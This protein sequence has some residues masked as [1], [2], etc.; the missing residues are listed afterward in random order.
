MWGW[1]G[2]SM[3]L[4]DKLKGIE[5]KVESFPAHGT[6]FIT[7]EQPITLIAGTDFPSNVEITIAFC[8][9]GG[10]SGS[11]TLSHSDTSS[12]GSVNNSGRT[13]IQDITLDTYGHIT[14]LVSATETVV[15]TD[16]WRDIDTTPVNGHTDESISSDWAYDHTASSTAHPRDTRSQVAGTYN[17]II[18]TDGDINTSGADV[19]ATLNMTNGV[20]TSHSTRTLTP[21]NIGAEPADSTI[22]KDADIGVNVLPKTN[23]SL[24]GSITE[25]VYDLVGVVWSADKGTIQ[26][27]TMGAGTTTFTSSLLPGQ[28]ITLRLTGGTTAGSTIVYPIMKWLKDV[29]TVSDDM[30]LVLWNDG[31]NLCGVGEDLV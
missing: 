29:P 23:P 26:K 2:F 25:E 17:T 15:N 4:A 9:G 27:K 30:Q 11:V 6:M 21:A 16:T 20:I 13:Y 3:I 1:G 22:L 12:Q 8:G 5:S 24:S 7:S 28:S 19:L 14:G 18:G 10:T 31:L